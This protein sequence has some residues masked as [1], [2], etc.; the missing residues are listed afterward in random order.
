MTYK[1]AEAI[2]ADDPAYL[3]TINLIDTVAK[4]AFYDDD[5]RRI[6]SELLLSALACAYCEGYKHRERMQ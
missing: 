1:T 4:D 6:V 3:S 2:V 5:G